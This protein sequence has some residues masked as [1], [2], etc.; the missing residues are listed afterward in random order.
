M[1][2]AD[3]LASGLRLTILLFRG[4]GDLMLTDTPGGRDALRDLVD[5]ELRDIVDDLTPTDRAMLSFA[6]KGFGLGDAGMSAM[7]ASVSTTPTDGSPGP[8]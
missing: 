5:P 4:V 3:V 6:T 7:S 2:A 8:R 1:I